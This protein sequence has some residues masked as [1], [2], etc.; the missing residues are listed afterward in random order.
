MKGEDR[1]ATTSER[2]VAG[3]NLSEPRKLDILARAEPDGL[4]SL[5]E[6]LLDDL[7]AVDVLSSRTGLAMVPREDSVTGTLFHLGEV[8]IAEAHIRVAGGVEGYGAIVGRDLERAM[9]MAVIDAAIAADRAPET[10]FAFLA[11]EAERQAADD[12]TRL[13]KVEA[14]R[15]EMEAF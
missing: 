12:A 2:A 13:A 15:V 1:A 8:L 11:A 7:G 5:A 4:K 9:A 6:S 3:R 14:T 10:V